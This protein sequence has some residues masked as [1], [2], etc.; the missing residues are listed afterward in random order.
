M[1]KVY[2]YDTVTQFGPDLIECVSKVD[3]NNLRELC[4]EMAEAL[5]HYEETYAWYPEESLTKYEQ[6][7][8]Q[9]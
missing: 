9:E 7:K 1:V 5:K 8:E 3:Y 4:D 6:L 2:Y